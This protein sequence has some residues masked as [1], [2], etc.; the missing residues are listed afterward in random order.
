MSE[1]QIFRNAEFGAVRV[2]EVAGAA[3]FVGTIFRR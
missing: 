2:V 3:W 1:M